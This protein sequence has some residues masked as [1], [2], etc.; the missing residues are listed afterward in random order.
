[1]RRA[2]QNTIF[3]GAGVYLWDLDRRA[4]HSFSF[5]GDA[6]FVRD[7]EL[8]VITGDEETSID[9]SAEGSF[10]LSVNAKTE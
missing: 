9:L 6:R 2:S 10:E 4:M 3:T 8:T 7:Q 1:M 5:R